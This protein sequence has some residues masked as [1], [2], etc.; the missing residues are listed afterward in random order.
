MSSPVALITGAGGEMGRLLVPALRSRGF[1]VV[2]LDL[3]FYHYQ[4]CRRWTKLSK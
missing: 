1:D 2:V 4:I 3:Q